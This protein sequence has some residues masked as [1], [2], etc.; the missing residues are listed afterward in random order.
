V[1]K[2]KTPISMLDFLRKARR[3]KR[4]VIGGIRLEPARPVHP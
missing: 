1:S 4:S 2:M 3:E